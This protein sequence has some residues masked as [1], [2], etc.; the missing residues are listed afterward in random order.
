MSLGHTGLVVAKKSISFPIVK[1]TLIE[2]ED[3]TSSSPMAVRRGFFSGL[4]RATTLR[5]DDVDW[6]DF[7]KSDRIDVLEREDLI[8]FL[9]GA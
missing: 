2:T 6:G 1:G 8:S 7:L 4:A 5:K 3:E 9:R